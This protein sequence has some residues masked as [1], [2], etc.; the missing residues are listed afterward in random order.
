MKVTLHNGRPFD[1]YSLFPHYNIN[2]AFE[3]LRNKLLN[4][5]YSNKSGEE[6]IEKFYNYLRINGLNSNLH[7]PDIPRFIG[8][9]KVCNINYEKA[10]NFFRLNYCRRIKMGD[11]F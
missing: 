2:I 1:F 5:K 9:A 6:K 10:L 8:Y 7:Y 3:N 11:E 4:E